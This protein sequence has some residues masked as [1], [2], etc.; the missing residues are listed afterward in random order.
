M[1][2]KRRAL[3]IYQLRSNLGDFDEAI[4]ADALAAATQYPMT[5]TADFEARLYVHAPEATSP[6][7]LELIQEGFGEDVQVTSSASN[8]ALIIIRLRYY[9]GLRYFALTFGGG[10]HMLNPAAVEK[11]Y[12]LRVALNSIYEGDRSDDQSAPARVKRVDAKTVAQNTL[13]TLRQTNRHATFEV[14]GLDVQRDLLNAVV[15]EPVDTVLWGTRIAG[16]DAISL[17]IPTA[18]D[19]LGEV[20]KRV[21]RLGRSKDY[22][23]RFDWI[24]NIHVVEDTALVSDLED[25]LVHTLLTGSVD[26]LALAPPQVIDWDRI[27]SFEFTV[28]QNQDFDDLRLTDYLALLLVDDTDRIDIGRLRRHRARAIDAGGNVAYEWPL[29]RCLSG[30]VRLNGTAYLLEDG[31][32]YEVDDGYMAA[33]DGFIAAIPACD[34]DLPDSYKTNGKELTEGAYNEQAA[35]DPQRLLLDKKTVKVSTHTSPIEICDLLTTDRRFIH[36]KRKLGSSDLSH[37]FA[38]GYVSA[39]LFLMSPDYRATVKDKIGETEQARAVAEN[40]AGFIGRFT[41]TLNFD[42]PDP[43]KIEVVY[44]VVAAWNGRSL[45]A[46]L[47]FFSKVNLRRHVDDLRRMGYR[48]TF[49]RVEVR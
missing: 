34:T 43:S 29:M 45:V 49:S 30:E 2:G 5:A 35:A 37:L 23:A 15:G 31:A 33:L 47:P 42:A 4:N 9:N 36:V 19:D 12:G 1:M 46:A 8:R 17:S 20:C 38:Q 21:W 44:A 41:G 39:D 6:G 18:F 24:D 25:Q 40:N 26:T 13:R 11:G 48:V 7:W 14:F 10:R 32:F 27:E 16:S 22:R 28:S 3:T